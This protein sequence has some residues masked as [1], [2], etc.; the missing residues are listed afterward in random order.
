MLPI[1][2]LEMPINPPLAERD[3]ALRGQIGPDARPLRHA[4]VQRDHARH[5]LLEALH[6]L[7]EGVA[8]ALDDLEQAEV[9]VAEPPAEQPGPA[10]ALDHALEIAE[11]FRHAIFPEI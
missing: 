3:A 4:F 5:L 11:E 7:R 6:P 1:Q 8:Q 10:A 2:L 9:H